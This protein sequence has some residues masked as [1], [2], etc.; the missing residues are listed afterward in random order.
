MSDSKALTFTNENFETEVLRSEQPVLVDFWAEWCG[1]CKAVGPVVDELA[2]EYAGRAKI[3]KVD[4]DSNKALAESYGIMSIPTLAIFANGELQATILG[5][6]PKGRLA[7]RL[8]Q[9]LVN[10]V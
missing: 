3:G 9:F 2:G 4:I 8:D 7:K 6:Q 10:A 1:P 5:A